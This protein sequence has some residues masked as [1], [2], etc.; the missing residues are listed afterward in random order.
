M[1]DQHQENTER[2]LSSSDKAVILVIAIGIAGYMYAGIADVG[3]ACFFSHSGLFADR[4]GQCEEQGGTFWKEDMGDGSD[5]LLSYMGA[6]L[7]DHTCTSG[8]YRNTY[9]QCD[10]PK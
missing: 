6:C 9:W 10:V 8:K 7:P 4:C 3:A 1:T 2:S 5:G